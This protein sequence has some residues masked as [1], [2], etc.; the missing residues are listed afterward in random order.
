VEGFPHVWSDRVS[1]VCGMRQIENVGRADRICGKNVNS[2][3]NVFLC[4]VLYIHT[5]SIDRFNTPSLS[6]N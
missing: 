3:Q 1:G 5:N 4:I 2:F 6:Y